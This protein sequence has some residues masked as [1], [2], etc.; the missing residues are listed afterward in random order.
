MS[1]NELRVLLSTAPDR[2]SAERIARSLVD[3]GLAACVQILPGLTSFYQSRGELERS[4]EL[5][6]LAKTCHPEPCLERLSEL[7]PYDVPEGIVLPVAG[8]L[9]AYLRWAACEEA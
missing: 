2:E 5:L 6:I 3:E 7:H 4:D 9:A 8:G 1:E